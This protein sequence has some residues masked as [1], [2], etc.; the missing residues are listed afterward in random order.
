MVVSDGKV[1]HIYIEKDISGE[2][3]S[4]KLEMFT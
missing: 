3:I 1:F 4:M 2:D